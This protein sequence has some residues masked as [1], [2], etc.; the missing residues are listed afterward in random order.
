MRD[1]IPIAKVQLV[2]DIRESKAISEAWEGLQTRELSDS[3]RNLYDQVSAYIRDSKSLDMVHFVQVFHQ[4]LS[5]FGNDSDWQELYKE[6]IIVMT[7]S[8]GAFPQELQPDAAMIRDYLANPHGQTEQ[9]Y[10][11]DEINGKW[12]EKFILKHMKEIAGIAAEKG[13]SVF[14][15]IGA[16]HVSNISEAFSDVPSSYRGMVKRVFMRTDIVPDEY[17]PKDGAMKTKDLGGIDLTPANMNL[18]TQNSGGE[19]KCFN[20]FRMLPALCR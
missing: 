15:L 19:I 8:T 1:Q 6:L 14:F 3:V 10:V 16:G 17:I 5:K 11:V 4:S 12:R 2:H 7:K 13:L 9:E 20:S 18:Q